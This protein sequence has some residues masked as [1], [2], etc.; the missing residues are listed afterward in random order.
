M[1]KKKFFRGNFLENFRDDSKWEEVTF[2]ERAVPFKKMTTRRILRNTGVDITP[3]FDEYL[4]V[5][6]QYIAGKMPDEKRSKLL[7]QSSG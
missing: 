1:F 4:P 5:I 3:V 2:E 7:S 6:L